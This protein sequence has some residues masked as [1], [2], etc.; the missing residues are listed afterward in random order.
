MVMGSQNPLNKLGVWDKMRE[1]GLAS[2]PPGAPWN[3]ALLQRTS[4]QSSSVIVS[5]CT[6]I[7]RTVLS[8]AWCLLSSIRIEFKRN[9]TLLFCMLGIVFSIFFISSA[10]I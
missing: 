1:D 9:L 3:G 2:Y 6:I 4:H 8:M 7:S 5:P 10:S